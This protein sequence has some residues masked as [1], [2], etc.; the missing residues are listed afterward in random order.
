MQ[1]IK[2]VQRGS[3]ADAIKYNLSKVDFVLVI[4]NDTQNNRTKTIQQFAAS[5]Y[6]VITFSAKDEKHERTIELLKEAVA[7]ITKEE[8]A[9]YITGDCV[10]DFPT[11][12]TKVHAWIERYVTELLQMKTITR[13]YTSAQTG[14]EIAGAKTLYANGVFVEVNAPSGFMQRRN[15]SDFKTSEASLVSQI[16]Q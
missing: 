2:V 12:E 14:A 5:P 8:I 11:L 3:Y 9:V 15:N 10:D 13:V 4:T 6:F 16:C 1:N 7:K